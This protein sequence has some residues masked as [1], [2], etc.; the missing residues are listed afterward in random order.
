VRITFSKRVDD[1]ATDPSNYYIIIPE[2]GHLLLDPSKP[3]E[4]TE[5]RT[6]VNLTTLSQSDA[7]YQVTVTGI[8]DLAGDPIAPPDMLV[9]PAVTTFTG[10][11]PNTLEEHIDTDG[12][13]FADWFEMLGWSIT[14]ELEDGQRVQGY[15]T[16]DPFNPD[17]DGDGVSDADENAHSMDPRTDDTDA[18][19]VLDADELWGWRS[20]PCDQDTDDDGFADM[21]EVEFGTSLILADTDGDQ[22]D[23]RDELL[24]R[25]RNPHIADLPIVSITVG[26]MNLELDERYS[27]TDQFGEDHQVQ[28][29]FSDTLQRDTSSATSETHS[30]VYRAHAQLTVKAGIE[31]GWGTQSG[32][33]VHGE[34][35]ATGGFAYERTNAWGTQSSVSTART[36]NEAISRVA[37]FSS[38]SGVT[39]E[40]VGARLLAAVTIGA[41]SDIAFQISDLE[42]SVLLQDPRDRSRLTPIATLVP[43][44][45]DAV[46]SVGPLVPEIGPLIFQNTEIFPS[47]VEELMKD[48]RGLV[49][50]VVNYNITDEFERNFAF[51]SQ[52]VVE[53]TA[54]VTI[55]YGNGQSETAR[56]ATA[57]RFD[58]QGQPEGISMEHALRAMTL[59]P[60]EG[61]D[62]ELGSVDDPEDPRPK[63][64]DPDIQESF[65]MRTVSATDEDGQPIDF[66]V[67]TRVRGV[68][69][70]FELETAEP[71]KPND[72]GFWVVFISMPAGRGA[73][74]DA[75][76][77]RG[78]TN[79]DEFRLHA[80][81]SYILAF[82]KDKDRDQL[83]SLEEFF[84]GSNDALS[85]TDR[86][87]LNDFLEVRGQWNADGLGAWLVYTDRLP[88][89]YQAY[90]APYLKDSDE[91]GLPDDVEY[92]LC[93]YRYEQD[94]AVPADV[95]AIGTYRD[96]LVDPGDDRVD[97]DDLS[98]DELPDAFPCD[99]VP[100][101]WHTEID[102]E[103]GVP[104]L[105]PTN[106]A[107][108]DPRKIDT[109][110]DGIR[111]GDEVNGYYV[112]LF[113][114]DP[115]DGFRTR[116]FVYSDPL[117]SDTDGDGLLDGMERQF[118]T[119]P[120]STDS[121]VVFDDD[122]DGLPNRVETSGWEVT[123]NGHLKT[124]FSN[125]NDPD[126]DNDNLPD[127]L[128]WV[129]GT[130]PWYYHPQQEPEPD[131]TAPGHDTDQDGLSDYDEW[132]GTVPPQDRDKLAFCDQ[133]P[134]CAGYEPFSAAHGTD[135]V[136]RDTD[137]DGI[138]DGRELDGWT[139]HVWRETVGYEVFSDPLRPD[140]DLDGLNDDEEWRGVDGLPANVHGL[141]GSGPNAGEPCNQDADCD[142]VGTCSAQEGRC[143]PLGIA[144]CFPD[145]VACTPVDE[146]NC[147]NAPPATADCL[148]YD[149]GCGN[150]PAFPA[151]YTACYND[152]CVSPRGDCLASGLCPADTACEENVF[153]CSGGPNPGIFCYD[154][155][156]C[157]QE[158]TCFPYEN[159]DATDPRV[160][161][162]DGDGTN[163]SA[164]H[165]LV[166]TDGQSRDP[167][168]PDQ[169]VTVSY[170]RF[171]VIKDGH[172][173][174]CLSARF[175]FE[176][177]V[178]W[179]AEQRT[180]IWVDSLGFFNRKRC[181]I[182]LPESPCTQDAD[183]PWGGTC[184]AG[185]CTCAVD[186]DCPSDVC[187]GDSGC[188]PSCVT[189]VDC[190]SSFVCAPDDV[191][192]PP[193]C[194]T[195]AECLPSV[196]A[197]PDHVVPICQ[198]GT[199]DAAACYADSLCPNGICQTQVNAP[200]VCTDMPG[201]GGWCIFDFMC[202]PSA[203][204]LNCWPRTFLTAGVFGC[205][206]YLYHDG[207]PCSSSDL[208]P[209][210]AAGGEPAFCNA[211]LAPPGTGDR[212]VCAD[213]PGDCS[214]N[215]HQCQGFGN[216]PEYVQ[217]NE[218]DQVL[219]E[220]YVG[221]T[222]RSFVVRYDEPFALHGYV[223]IAKT[224]DSLGNVL[225]TVHQTLYEWRPTEI[226]TLPIET[227][228]RE[229]EFKTEAGA[230]AAGDD[231]EDVELHL[232][233]WLFVE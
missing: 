37:Q 175:M 167:V 78:T 102:P 6:V 99:G 165:E 196:C 111:D 69:D 98:P 168:I 188:A 10:I 158:H 94:A 93:R 67:I 174:D 164:E 68:Q 86:D 54:S 230:H 83:T 172:G 223:R 128:E 149:D 141:C 206:E 33:K 65:G 55:D 212:G 207:H 214:S 189:D 44:E 2:G 34:I 122:L 117:S 193:P 109:D 16:S 225:D 25:N 101:E 229:L 161:D 182:P 171:N 227:P 209:G 126:S 53:R 90:S 146:V 76:A 82:V 56:I 198:G 12:D 74:S 134:N 153:V 123:I 151:D 150:C 60:W 133:V 127:Y 156:E 50:K 95:F 87:D 176:F 72:G 119:N 14:I 178:R 145:R 17:T 231:T 177:G 219:F 173:D 23:D 110:E 13:G 43:N 124:V 218:N 115:T 130:S 35:E 28:E 210:Q 138:T 84:S 211:D 36:Y 144:D 66:R 45:P 85:D 191:C 47:L 48:P 135:P 220:A 27:Y 39:R 104:L 205:C 179:P 15:V 195:D 224:K 91:D 88:G 129:L 4:L 9:N 147:P 107:A 7:L 199:E 40:T 148:P 181:R 203:D 118:G 26:E 140:T 213:P 1:D 143:S 216:F 59:L 100:E 11:A 137:G 157:T 131:E 186:A 162:T 154:D 215:Y 200:P 217:L 202:G 160:R 61:E 170:D 79:F 20:N 132:D 63:P 51:S 8:H 152:V 30:D 185:I 75:P 97:W 136:D 62:P 49:F 81:E 3:P 77:L 190:P 108:L 22:L 194:E 57:G 226:F 221:E 142:F 31:Q 92:A 24:Y 201:D 52:E 116:V 5:A 80:G 159:R 41:A 106:R 233:G 70:D 21:T 184:T 105:F 222:T 114:D 192:R 46:Y 38:T 96:T 112:D 18:D 19:L 166:A 139:V 204:C 208:C 71:D 169:L 163:D 183:C 120:V 197:Q 29:S 58:P 64:V 89:G 32:G 103:T 113:D 121:G 155:A 232:Y 180:E 73:E 228:F 187:M 125:P 42:I